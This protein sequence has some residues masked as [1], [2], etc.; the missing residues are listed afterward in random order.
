MLRAAGLVSYYGD[1]RA[2]NEVTVDIPKGAIIALI[3]RNGAGKSTLFKVLCGLI[4]LEAGEIHFEDTQLAGLAPHQIIAKGISYAPQGAKMFPDLTI[5]E[6]LRT[7]TAKGKHYDAT[8]SRLHELFIEAI[9]LRESLLIRMLDSLL[10]ARKDQLGKTLS[11]GERQVVA[12]ARSLHA[13]PRLIL[14]D[15]PSIGLAPAV[16]PELE[17]LM[18]YLV[19]LGKTILLIDQRVEWAL[20]TCTIV[21][22]MRE[23]QIAYGGNPQRLL[24]DRQYLLTLLGL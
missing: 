5:E 11:G 22:V 20:Q 13:D 21:Y 6:N 24:E 14:L 3:G 15:E 1:V 4:K 12:L 9:K 18:Q 10:G 17:L 16:L 19:S 8:F 7:V 23:G 2:L